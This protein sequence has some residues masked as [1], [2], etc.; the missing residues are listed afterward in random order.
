MFHVPQTVPLMSAIK[1]GHVRDTSVIRVLAPPLPPAA[2]VCASLASILGP[3]LPLVPGHV[4]PGPA[5]PHYVRGP[6][7]R[8]SRPV[9][10]P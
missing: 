4:A 1:A 2:A 6:D 7:V 5:V 8:P 10:R 9:R 3:G